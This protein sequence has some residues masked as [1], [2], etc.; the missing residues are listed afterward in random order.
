MSDANPS[1][2]EGL[3]LEDLFVGQRFVSETYEMTPERIIAFASEFDPQYFHTDPE[4]AKSSFFQGLAASGWHTAAVSMKLLVQAFPLAEGVI[5]G[6][7]GELAW[8]QATRPGDVL[9]LEVEVTEIIPSRSKPNRALVKY[10]NETKNQRG[11]IV[12]IACP[13]GVVHKRPQA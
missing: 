4:R 10:R 8:P 2:P 1:K 11:E 7:M 5:G 13:L 12:Q 3:Y 6:G 9:H